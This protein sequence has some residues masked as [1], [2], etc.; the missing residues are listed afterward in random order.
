MAS[1]LIGALRV[2]MALDS[3]QFSKGAAAVK[4]SLGR[5]GSAFK[6]LGTIAVSGMAVAA[7]AISVAMKSVADDA[8]KIAKASQKLGVA[9]DELQK[10]RYAANLSGVS[11][12]QLETGITKLTQS[13]SD[14]AKGGTSDAAKAFVALGVN[15]KTAEG[16]LKSADVVLSELAGKF[17][18]Y[19]DGAEK[20]AL[21]LAIFGRSGAAMIPMLNQGSE[22]LEKAKNEAAEL[23]AVMST[24][25]Q[26]ASEQA[27][28]NWSRL[29]TVFTGIYVQMAEQLIPSAAT[30]TDKIVEW[31]KKTKIAFTI[32]EDFADVLRRI[33]D[34]AVATYSFIM[35]LAEGIKFLGR[36]AAS[37]FGNKPIDLIAAESKQRIIDITK[38]YKKFQDMLYSPPSLTIRKKAILP[39][40]PTL[41]KPVKAA[42]AAKAAKEEKDPFDA[43]V[44]NAEIYIAKQNALTSAIG[45][46]AVKALELQYNQD[47]LN[48]AT[49][50]G[51][52]LTDA[53]KETLG[54]L[55]ERMA[56]AAQ[57][58]KDAKANFDFAK[59]ATLGFI[60]T[61]RQGLQNGEKFWAS[62]GK[63]ALSVLNKIIDKIEKQLVDALFSLGSAGSG[64][65]GIFGAIFKGIGAA[66]GAGN[67]VAAGDMWTGFANG[68]Q[69][70]VG[71]A[72]GIDSQVVAFKASPNETVSVTKPGQSFGNNGGQQE[73]VVRG[74]FV[75]D[76]GVIKAHVQS[77]INQAAPAIVGAS[78]SQTQKM[79]PNMISSVQSRAA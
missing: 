14:V 3:A 56:I 61:L 33:A 54:G 53:Q 48:K 51:I 67:G 63:A 10:L 55:A 52:A 21:A 16:G 29:G 15:V 5:L 71:G 59:G 44:R 27:N 47:L 57:A 28:D 13:M 76:G 49:A 72:G 20:T 22:A 1:S 23:G 7:A 38:E 39:A 45:L 70:K 26:S 46:T 2:S 62:F 30:L 40:A 78:V 6:N 69:F 42:K 11:F 17:S 8:D 4:S 73:V 24:K 34:M 50:K 37:A 68:G 12:E 36:A 41:S 66:F 77:S 64:G 43:I 60:Q 32:G 79:L 35:I 25:L 19:R 18:Q 58:A 74:V 65:G 9:S 75:D 31:A